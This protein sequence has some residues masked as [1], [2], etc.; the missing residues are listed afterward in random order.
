MPKLPVLK[1][2]VVI[3]K[4]KKKGFIVDHVTGSHYVLYKE[5]LS[6]PITVPFHNKDLKPGTLHSI[7]KQAGL[8]IEEF[9]SVK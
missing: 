3:H 5:G 6:N 2:K 8:N 1:P 7:I 9:I 4:L